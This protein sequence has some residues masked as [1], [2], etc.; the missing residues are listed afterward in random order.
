MKTIEGGEKNLKKSLLTQGSDESR[1]EPWQ[2]HNES[3][4]VIEQ[5]FHK[6]LEEEA[7]YEIQ[8]GLYEQQEFQI[9]QEALREI[10]GIE[11][12]SEGVGIKGGTA[13]VLLMDHLQIVGPTRIADI[14]LIFTKE[15]LESEG[16]VEIATAAVLEHM[17]DAEHLDPG[18]LIYTGI[19]DNREEYMRTHD[20][21]MNELYY[22]DGKIVATKQCVE[23]L[24]EGVVRLTTHAKMRQIEDN[25]PESGAKLMAKAIRF[26]AKESY[27]RGEA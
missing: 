14:D 7:A 25:A 22:L 13:R 4:E 23:D 18:V 15:L 26:W 12:L 1:E 27:V 24:R 6:W 16:G 9:S 19:V 20:F 21:S 3:L 2:I 11:S 8:E 10:T 17:D 5:R